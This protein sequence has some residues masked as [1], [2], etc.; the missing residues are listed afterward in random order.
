MS[1]DS[2]VLFRD[3]LV[4][5]LVRDL[6][7]IKREIA[8]YPDDETLWRVVPGISNAGGTLALH[9][10][11]NLRHFVGAVLGQSGYRRDRDAEFAARGV[12]REQIAAELDDAIA[13]VTLALQKLDAA[14]MAT[15]YPIAVVEL[16]VPTGPY[17]VHLASHLAYHLGQLDYH[18]RIVTGS[19]QTVET[20]KIPALF[21]PNV[22]SHA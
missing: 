16:N 11:G 5:I 1:T 3:T 12:T 20:M 19:A 22:P 17:L 10:A 13:A 4:R 2:N 15:E 18:R 21:V 6:A 8:A 14:A 9:A 7:A